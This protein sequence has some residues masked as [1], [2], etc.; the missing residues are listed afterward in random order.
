MAG[1][2]AA[3]LDYEVGSAWRPCTEDGEKQR[4]RVWVPEDTAELPCVPRLVNL[5][6]FYLGKK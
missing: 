4:L 2:P 6:L 1:A 5:R 3:M